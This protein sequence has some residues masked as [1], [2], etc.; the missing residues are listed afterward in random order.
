M[1]ELL[2]VLRRSPVIAAVR[3][4]E[5]LDAALASPVRIVF[6]LGGDP[7]TLPALT[8]RVREAGRPVF[9][10]MDLVE[11]VGRDAAGVRWIARMVKPEGILS[12]RAP[13]L[14]AAAGEGLRTVLRMFLVDSSSLESGER[15][16]K[17]CAP[18]LVE[19]MPGL[20]TRAIAR[21]GRSIAQPVIGGGMLERRA[22]VEAVLR[23][24]AL[25]ASTSNAA[26]WT[27]AAWQDGKENGE[28]DGQ[29]NGYGQP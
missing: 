13:L 23:A 2:E 11:G 19:V 18:D 27:L 21:L 1:K 28:Y 14:R 6:L 4:Q 12:T 7:F 25:A 22:D 3:G 29:N 8:R 5:A 20:A 16:I 10:H 26:L 9:V 17:S 24:G 15:M